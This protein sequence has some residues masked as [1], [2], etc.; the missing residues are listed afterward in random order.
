MASR[1]SASSPASM[2]IVLTRE[3]AIPSGYQRIT[4]QTSCSSSD[5]DLQQVLRS[6]AGSA[7]IAR[8]VKTTEW[9]DGC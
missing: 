8:R 9:P 4:P 3:V 5:A 6:G 1:V 7:L 2:S